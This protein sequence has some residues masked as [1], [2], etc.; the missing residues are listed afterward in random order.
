[1]DLIAQ[2]IA[3]DVLDGDEVGALARTDFVN[4]RDVWMI[5]GSGD[6]GLLFKA[7]HSIPVRSNSGRQNL[8]RDLAMQSHVFRQINFAHAPFAEQC[9][10]LVMVETSIQK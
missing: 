2:S 6:G 9:S 1:M 10:N 3:V 7:A 4:M 8:Q 5:E